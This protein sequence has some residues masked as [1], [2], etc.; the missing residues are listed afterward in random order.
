MVVCRSRVVWLHARCQARPFV[1]P[2][3]SPPVLTNRWCPGPDV[4]TRVSCRSSPG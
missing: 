1:E 3:L 2:G 4:S